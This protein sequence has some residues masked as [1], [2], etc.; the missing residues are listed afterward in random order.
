ME[1]KKSKPSHGRLDGRQTIGYQYE[2][3]R[4]TRKKGKF[5]PRGTVRLREFLYCDGRHG[6]VVQIILIPPDKLSKGNEQRV[7]VDK[8]LDL[9]RED[10]KF[11]EGA[12]TS[13]ELSGEIREYTSKKLIC[14]SDILTNQEK[15][16]VFASARRIK[17]SKKRQRR[18]RHWR[19]RFQIAV[20]LTFFLLGLTSGGL[21]QKYGLFEL[22]GNS[23]Y[24][25]Y[26]VDSINTVKE[27]I[28]D[29]S[30]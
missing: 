24:Q 4:A 5:L 10:K 18:A 17:D 2:F 12:L 19:I 7:L 3:P 29:I 23:F 15:I 21:M 16:G 30:R 6:Q 11:R 27:I 13:K 1:H 14:L 26:I 28:R 8:M 25:S 20:T 22:K 9:N